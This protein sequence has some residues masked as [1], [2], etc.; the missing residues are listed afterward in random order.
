MSESID[1]L[2]VD[3]RV[4][5]FNR[6]AVGL[7]RAIHR[8]QPELKIVACYMRN[9]APQ[10]IDEFSDTFC[11]KKYNYNASQ[12][13]EE[14]HPKAV[15]T[16]AHRF[17]DYLFTTKAHEKGLYVYNFQHGLYMENTVISDL[18]ANSLASVYKN[19]KEKL[20]IYLKCSANLC[21]H[22]FKEMCRFA[23]LFLRK[24]SLYVVMNMMFETKCNADVSYVYGEYWKTYYRK[25]YLETS[26][27]FLVVGYPELEDETERVSLELFSGREKPVLCYLA[28]TSVEDGIVEE[29][30]LAEFIERLKKLVANYNL[31]IKF[32][33]RS[34]RAMYAALLAERGVAVWDKGI[35]PE[36]DL[37]IGHESA[38]M[39]RALSVTSKTLVCR[40]LAERVSPFE[41]YTCYS[42]MPDEN[43]NAAVETALHA[44]E[45]KVH[46]SE[47]AFWNRNEGAIAA[48]ARDMMQRYNNLKNIKVLGEKR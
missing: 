43:L 40:L 26:S 47:Y 9:A 5:G 23:S 29:A 6:Y 35:F 4:E 12:I 33:P 15:L 10:K 7:C 18:S 22:R 28:Q 16:F 37:Y 25:K 1:L 39:A 24:K 41:R 2:V 27:E 42:V 36:A 32:H 38:V 11:A 14:Y 20:R 19:K 3:Y 30:V 21:E 13:L 34:N 48:T 46:I 17:F 44:E 8:I 45:T 31:L